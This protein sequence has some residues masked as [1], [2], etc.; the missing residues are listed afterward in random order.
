MRNVQSR[1]G[2]IDIVCVDAGDLVF[3]EVRQRG[4]ARYGGAAAS[5]GRSKQARLIRTA[6]VW[7]PRLVTRY[8]GGQI[9]PCR[10]DVVA[11]QQGRIDWLK[12]AF[13]GDG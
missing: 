11:V 10:F 7:L 8:F 13:P 6:Q 12:Q 9:P 1:H 5:V 2:E 4:H 3:V